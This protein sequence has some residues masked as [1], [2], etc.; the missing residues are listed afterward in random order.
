MQTKSTQQTAAA[1]AIEHFFETPSNYAH[2]GNVAALVLERLP[3]DTYAWLRPEA[4]PNPAE[5]D[6]ALFWPTQ[7][8][9]DLVARWR[10]EAALFGP[11]VPEAG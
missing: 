1:A 6:D 9:R 10:A 5:P 2:A 4:D 8:G 3:N 7:A 11:V